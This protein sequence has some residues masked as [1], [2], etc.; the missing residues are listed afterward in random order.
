MNGRQTFR[1]GVLLLLQHAAEAAHDRE[2]NAKQGQDGEDDAERQ[3]H[4]A[5]DDRADNWAHHFLWL[6]F[7]LFILRVFVFRCVSS[8]KQGLSVLTH[9]GLSRK[10][11][12]IAPLALVRVN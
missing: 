4:H 5:H 1:L 3:H 11:P 8:R 6:E 12:R 10:E 2:K 7:D 9:E